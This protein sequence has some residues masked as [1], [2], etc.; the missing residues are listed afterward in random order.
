MDTLNLILAL[1]LVA[2]VGMAALLSF[3]VARIKYRRVMQAISQAINLSKEDA[4]MMGERR[5]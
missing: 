5:D 4:K 2:M 3:M 1:V